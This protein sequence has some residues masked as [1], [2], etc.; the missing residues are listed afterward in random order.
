MRL[1]FADYDLPTVARVLL[2]LYTG[3]YHDEVYPNL[4]HPLKSSIATSPLVGANSHQN[5]SQQQ[6]EEG[7]NIKDSPLTFGVGPTNSTGIKIWAVKNLDV[8]LCAKALK[9]DLLKTLA[10]TK[11]DFRCR[12]DV[13]SASLVA[14]FSYIYDRISFGD[15]DLRTMLLRICFENHDLVQRDGELVNVLKRHEPITWTLLAEMLLKVPEMPVPAVSSNK[16]LQAEIDLLRAENERLKK[17]THSTTPMTTALVKYKASDS[18]LESEVVSL[19]ARMKLLRAENGHLKTETSTL[20]QANQILVKEQDAQKSKP[21]QEDGKQRKREHAANMRI[22]FLEGKVRYL[23]NQ[24]RNAE[25]RLR[26]LV[27][28]LNDAESRLRHADAQNY[29]WGKLHREKKA[30]RSEVEWLEGMLKDAQ[31][32]VKETRECKHCDKAFWALLKVD[33]N[34]DDVCVKCGNC[35]QK[36]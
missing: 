1:E 31:T 30:L 13:S 14:T 17:D 10:L 21:D 34:Q 22:S 20:T 16:G 36:H 2:Y 24:L 12:S 11:L 8:Y 32:L 27:N 3:K 5:V 19:N 23:V 25:S 4:G 29:A 35:G 33:L 6:E 9:I 7:R 28:Q 18:G 15:T 26:Y